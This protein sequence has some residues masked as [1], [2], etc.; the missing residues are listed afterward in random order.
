MTPCDVVVERLAL[1]EPLDSLAAHVAGCARCTRLVAMPRQL[2][3]ARSAVDP[4]LG[5]SA[6]M[7]AGA[8]HRIGVR[9]RRRVAMG[10][11][12]T[13]AA[14]ALGV[15]FF[16]RDPERAAPQPVAATSVP[17]PT[18]TGEPDPAAPILEEDLQ[19]LV[20]FADP[21]RSLQV[22]ANWSDIEAPIEPYGKLVE[23][24][25]GEEP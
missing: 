13:V 16:M 24:V 23:E 18:P 9:R 22:S 11:A 25:T 12:A 4:G 8:Q 5:F 1:G 20:D 7:T 3:A 17:V 14:G 21:E 19:M 6:R 15:V 10:L 2:S